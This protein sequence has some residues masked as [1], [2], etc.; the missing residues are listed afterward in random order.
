MYCAPFKNGGYPEI[1]EVE[2]AYGI[3][4]FITPNQDFILVDAPKENENNKDRDIHV[5]FKKGDGT[6]TLPISLGEQ[7]N[8]EFT[9]TCPSLS[10]DGKYLFFSRYNEENSMSNIYWVSAEI[11]NQI[12]PDDLD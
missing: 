1:N 9:E 4:G 8:S 7:V 11:I 6:W 2:I 5:C 3:H 10:S 12:R